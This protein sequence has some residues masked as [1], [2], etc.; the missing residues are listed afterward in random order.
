MS[1][2][3]RYDVRGFIAVPWLCEHV[4][5]I[6]GPGREELSP[7]LLPPLLL[8]RR[9]R[10]RRQAEQTLL[11][12]LPAYL[13]KQEWPE[14]PGSGEGASARTVW[15]GGTGDHRGHLGGHSGPSGRQMVEQSPPV[16]VGVGVWNMWQL[17]L[18]FPSFLCWKGEEEEEED[19]DDDDD[20]EGGLHKERKGASWRRRRRRR[21]RIGAA[22]FFCSLLPL[23]K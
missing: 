20:E 4:S 17:L 5:V 10:R 21:R 16:Q 22:E 6:N 3:R 18:P 14:W 7:R 12:V 15:S 13:G 11:L 19:D 1:R 2:Q 23:E 9:R 8:L